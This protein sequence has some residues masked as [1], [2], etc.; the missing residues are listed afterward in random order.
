MHVCVSIVLRKHEAFVDLLLRLDKQKHEP[1]FNS[2]LGNKK[3]PTFDTFLLPVTLPFWFSH[4]LLFIPHLICLKLASGALNLCSLDQVTQST[5]EPERSEAQAKSPSCVWKIF[6]RGGFYRGAS[7][8][9]KSPPSGAA[10]L[11]ETATKWNYKSPFWCRCSLISLLCPQHAVSIS[12]AGLGTIG[13]DMSAWA[14]GRW[15]RKK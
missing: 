9:A 8:L 2:S 4:L 12:P 3:N 11:I 14:P 13:G 10:I 1:L 5:K 6:S 7:V 15:E